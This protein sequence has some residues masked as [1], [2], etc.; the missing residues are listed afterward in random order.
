[1]EKKNSNLKSNV[2][3]GAS[4]T[5]GAAIGVAAG[6]AFTQPVQAAELEEPT[7]TPQ[8]QN[9]QVQAAKPEPVKPEPTSEP[10]PVKPSTEPVTTDPVTTEEPDVQVVSYE[11]VTNEDGSQMDVAVVAVEGEAVIIGDL[12]Q[13]G[14]ADVMAH[15]ENHNGQLET[16]EVQDISGQQLAMQPLHDAVD[17]NMGGYMAQN[18]SEPDYTNDANVDA[19]MA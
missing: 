1:M 10:E 7:V 18:D 13:D 5:V 8:A 6:T 9:A 16:N 17:P 11:T 12:N 3:T 14:I 19:Y 15:D 2:A 4:S